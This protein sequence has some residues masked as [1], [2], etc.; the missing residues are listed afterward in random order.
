MSF[1]SLVCSVKFIMWREYGITHAPGVIRG[2][3]PTTGA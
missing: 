1:L 2:D 3:K